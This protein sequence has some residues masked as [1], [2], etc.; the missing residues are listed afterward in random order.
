MSAARY[1]GPLRLGV[2]AT[3]LVVGIT[4]LVTGGCAAGPSPQVVQQFQNTIPTCSGD[5]DCKA[6]WEAAQLWVVHN[7]GFKIQT[8]TDVLIETYNATGGSPSIAARVTKE[9]LG[10]GRY[11]LV[12]FVTCDN[13]FGCVPDSWQ[14]ALNFNQVVGAATP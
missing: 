1:F 3:V 11:R 2:L 10:G 7:A 5:A 8:A 14:A 12:V 6:K 9:P 4:A 13:M